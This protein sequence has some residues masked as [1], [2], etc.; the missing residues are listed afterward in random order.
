MK[1]CKRC[2]HV[3]YYPTSNT[4]ECLTRKVEANGVCDRFQENLSPSAIMKK[5]DKE[6][7]R[8]EKMED[9]AYKL[10]QYPDFWQNYHLIKGENK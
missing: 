2:G 3:N 1:C 8:L 4:Y 7:A 6:I 10:K 5:I 9:G